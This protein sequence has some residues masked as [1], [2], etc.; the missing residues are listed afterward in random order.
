MIFALEEIIQYKDL[1]D[2]VT[3]VPIN[4]KKKAERGFNQSEVIARE[5]AKNIQKAYHPFLREKHNYKTQRKLGYRDRFLNI[6]G[7][8]AVKNPDLNRKYIKGK[9]III[10]DDVFTTGATINEC[11]RILKSFG[12]DRVYSLTIARADIKRVDKFSI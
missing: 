10:I 4:R 9:K 7:R 11:A 6:L 1:I 12:A 2:V 8:Y 3:C 5:L